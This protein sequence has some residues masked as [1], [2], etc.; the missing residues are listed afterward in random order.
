MRVIYEVSMFVGPIVAV[1]LLLGAGQNIHSRESWWLAM[2]CAGI[3][4]VAG[5]LS[6]VLPAWRP[7]GRYAMV[8]LLATMIYVTSQEPERFWSD[9]TFALLFLMGAWSLV[10]L[11]SAPEEA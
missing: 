1:V 9:L 3:G 6:P 4:A 7:L 10:A 11:Q 2:T 8:G 5:V